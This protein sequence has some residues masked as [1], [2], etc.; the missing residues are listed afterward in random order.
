MM[1]PDDVRTIVIVGVLTAAVIAV[2]C[3]ISGNLQGEDAAIQNA[4][5][6]CTHATVGHSYGLYICSGEYS[7]K[8]RTQ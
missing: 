4:L 5:P 8:K 3:F 2:I 7:Y 6:D 1:H